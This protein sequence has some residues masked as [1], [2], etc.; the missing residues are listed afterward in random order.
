[1]RTIPSLS[2][3]T[4]FTWD[5]FDA[6]MHTVDSYQGKD[7]A[8]LGPKGTIPAVAVIKMNERRENPFK[9]RK[10]FDSTNFPVN[11]NSSLNDVKLQIEDEEE[12]EVGLDKA[13]LADMED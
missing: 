8:Y 6:W 11:G 5:R 2:F 4:A 3:Q 13:K 9:E 1:V 7:L 10:K 12:E